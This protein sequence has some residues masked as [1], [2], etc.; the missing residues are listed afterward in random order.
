MT[1]IS[2]IANRFIYR[3]IEFFRHWYIKS[4]RIY[5]NFVINIFQAVDRYFAW[6][7]TLHFIFHPLY[8]DYTI[9]GYALGFIFR[10]LRLIVAL[11]I[12]AVMFFIAVIL[13]AIW[14]IIPPYLILRP[15]IN[16]LF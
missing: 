13:Y 8:G 1:A 12:Y 2:Y 10:I 11:I 7:V 14:V 6:K 3:I 16:Y 15:F 4:V 5:L 9:I